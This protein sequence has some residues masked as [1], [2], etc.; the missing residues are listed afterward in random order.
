MIKCDKCFY[1]FDGICANHSN[2]DIDSKCPDIQDDFDGLTL[3]SYG[4]DVIY[5][6][7][8]DGFRKAFP[9]LSPQ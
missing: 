8:C 9:F 1:N 7:M 2:A 6:N 4:I 5:I 3:D